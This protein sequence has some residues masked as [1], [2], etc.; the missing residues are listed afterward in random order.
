MNCAYLRKSR[1]DRDA[2]LRGEGETL[3]RH[4]ELITEYA[5]SLNIKIEKFYCEVVSGETI[6]ARPVMQELLADVEA[7]MWEGVFV[8]EVERLARGN[9]KDQGIVAEAFQLSSTKI[10][11]LTK[12]YDPNDEFDEEY[13]E[14]GL[15]MSRR[16]YKTI[17]R[18]LQRGRIASVKNGYYIASTAPYG[19]RKVKNKQDKGYTL[20]IIPEEAEVVRM[21]FEWYCK[22]E[23][24]PDGSYLPIGT[25]RIAS[26]L[27]RMGIKPAANSTWSRSTI[28][29]M[30]RN[31]TYTGKV[32]WGKKKEQKTY[33]DGA[34]K[35]TRKDS[36][37]YIVA[38][39]LHEA[40]IP[41]ELFDKAAKMR[42]IRQKCT[43]PAKC[44][45][46]NPFS[47]IIH[48]RKCGA[49]MTRLAPSPKNNYAK[50]K[51][52]NKY[53]DN[54]S[55]PL[56]LVEEQIL[57][58]LEDWLKTYELSSQEQS[59]PAHEEIAVKEKPLKK[60]DEEITAYQ[61]Q[62]NKA[63]DLLERDIYTLEVFQQRHDYITNEIQALSQNREL[64]QS[65]I[66]RLKAIQVK[67]EEFAPKVRKLLDTYQG[68]TP[69]ANNTILRELLENVL[70][71]K[72]EPNRRGNLYN[73]NF[74]LN[75]FPRIPS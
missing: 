52:P 71:E 61:S 20:E 56:F 47:G 18:R 50:L 41:D 12:I 10:Y 30:L 36:E 55:S 3:K 14:F 23:L 68:N 16:E 62:L 70:Y 51:C 48:C 15:F 65:E 58:F 22:G 28:G 32:C 19:Y 7:G 4:R 31:I 5:D 44:T 75:I 38:D 57:L 25:D 67:Q 64:L 73:A 13:F 29:D 26:K 9:T 54:I 72:K 45:L 34:L 27:D 6:E 40:I 17:N 63:F 1:A 33:Q 74:E 46:Q 42:S 21:V 43:T 39:G 53:C 69:K 8:V 60:L 35:K 24:Q 37:D 2:E 59:L 49:L 11:T 66:S